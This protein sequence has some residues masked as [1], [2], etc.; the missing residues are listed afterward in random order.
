MEGCSSP[1]LLASVLEEQPFRNGL[2]VKSLRTPLIAA[3]ARSAP[4]PPPTAAAQFCSLV[5]SRFREGHADSRSRRKA[6]RDSNGKEEKENKGQTSLGAHVA[7]TGMSLSFGLTPMSNSAHSEEADSTLR[8]L[9]D[10][11]LCNSFA[12]SCANRFEKP[13]G[14][15]SRCLAASFVPAT[16]YLRASTAVCSSEQQ[17]PQQCPYLAASLRECN[18]RKQPHELCR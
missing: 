5:S 18:D 14:C 7:L 6:C 3:A 1:G 13:N 4:S 9:D 15:A 12:Q 8:V 2:S 17:Y 10:H 16:L 11:G